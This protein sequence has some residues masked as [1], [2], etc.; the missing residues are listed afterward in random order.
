MNFNLLRVP[1]L[2]NFLCIFIYFCEFLLYFKASQRDQACP[3]GGQPAQRASKHRRR[4]AN[5]ANEPNRA[6]GLYVRPQ[7]QNRPSRSQIHVLGIKKRRNTTN[8]MEIKKTTFQGL[9]LRSRWL[10]SYGLVRFTEKTN[11]NT[12]P[13]D[14]L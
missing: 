11:R 7:G 6:Q 9:F 14:L 12:V 10:E 4:P 8:V 2:V 3:G 13:A 5:L 1:T